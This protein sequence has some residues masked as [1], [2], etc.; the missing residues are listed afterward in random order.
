MKWN[1]NKINSSVDI[2]KHQKNVR[3]KVLFL[4]KEEGRSL[5]TPK[6]FSLKKNQTSYHAFLATSIEGITLG[7]G[8]R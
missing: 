2:S 6:S 5:Y 7:D 4:W 8:E 1:K 3:E